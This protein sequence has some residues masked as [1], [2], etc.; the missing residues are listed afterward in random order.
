ME[1]AEAKA[2]YRLRGQTIEI[3]FADVKEHRGLRRFSGHGLAQVRTEFALEVLLHNLLV[4]HRSLRQ[5]SDVESINRM[6]DGI[7]A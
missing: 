2:V 6:T 1:T 7:A 3:V 5:K 4:M